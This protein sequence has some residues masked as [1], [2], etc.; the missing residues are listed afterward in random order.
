MTMLLARRSF[1]SGLVSLFAAPVVVRAESLMPV[2][3]LHVPKL[4]FVNTETG[5][6]DIFSSS[7]AKYG[8]LPCDGRT[9]SGLSYPKLFES[10]R[11]YAPRDDEWLHIAHEEGHRF[12]SDTD[13]SYAGP[14][15]YRD[16]YEGLDLDKEFLRRIEFG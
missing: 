14:A 2:S 5:V 6:F 3:A 10:V 13:V 15:V 11:G 4:K 8:W 9:V 1:L 16:L 12:N 7:V